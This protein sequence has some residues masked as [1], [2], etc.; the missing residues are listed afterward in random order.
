[1]IRGLAGAA[2]IAL[3]GAMLSALAGCGGTAATGNNAVAA[4][5]ADKAQVTITS[6]DTHHVFTV[7]V[8]RSAAAQE[9]G[10]MYR[11]NIPA[12]GGMLFAPYPPGGGPPVPASFW[13]KNTP[14]PLDIIFIRPDHTI[15]RVAEN[16][17][18]FDE[19]PIASGEPVSAVLEI[20]GG[21][22][23]A[24]GI[25]EGDTVTWTDAQR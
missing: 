6:G 25:G 2:R 17:V 14:S 13:M 8:A 4:P 20:N 24:L 10:L 18:P 23:T 5:V 12:D 19:T 1:M 9:R 3:A 21:R 22:A 7:E 11:T 16:A 15:A